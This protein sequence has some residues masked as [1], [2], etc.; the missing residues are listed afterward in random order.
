MLS[1]A[2]ISLTDPDSSAF[3]Y[4]VS[5]VS[6]GVFQTSPDGTTWTDATSFTTAQ[7]AAGHV[8][9]LHDG[10][11]TAPTFSI[12]ANDGQA[13]S[14]SVSGS[15]TFTNVN[16]APTA[17][18]LNAAETY[19]EGTA[20][21]LA[22]IVVSDVDSPNVT[23]TLTLSNKAAGSLSTGTSNAVTS[24]YD[25]GTGVWTASG[26]IADVNALLAGVTFNPAAGFNG[27]FAIA[28]NVSDGPAVGVRQQVDHRHRGEPRAGR[29][30]RHGDDQRGR[31]EGV[32]CGRLRFQRHRR[33]F[34]G[35]GGISSLPAAGTLLYDGS[36]IV[37][38]QVNAGFEVSAADLRP[39]S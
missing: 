20:L 37:T 15:V 2:N 26:A 18:N 7:V 33:Q 24:S 36:A 34:A 6:H 25:A 14:N 39:A 30:R 5:G 9:F 35:G 8:R 21:N 29:Q 28:T 22:D 4:T 27:N 16:D 23:A 31:R 1:A 11:E 3:T 17:T 10:G 32:C 12:K 38:E 13:D 19:T